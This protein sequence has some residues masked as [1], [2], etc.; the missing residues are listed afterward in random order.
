MRKLGRRQ[1]NLRHCWHSHA[2][3]L[4]CVVIHFLWNSG[5]LDYNLPSADSFLAVAVSDFFCNP[6][7]EIIANSSKKLSIGCEVHFLIENSAICMSLHRANCKQFWEC[8]DALHAKMARSYWYLVPKSRLPISKLMFWQRPF[9]SFDPSDRGKWDIIRIFGSCRKRRFPIIWAELIPLRQL[10]W[11]NPSNQIGGK[12]SKHWKD[13]ERRGM[14]EMKYGRD[15]V[16]IQVLLSYIFWTSVYFFP[17]LWGPLM[18]IACAPQCSFV[19]HGVSFFV[20]L[21]WHWAGVRL[22][23]SHK[24]WINWASSKWAVE[25]ESIPAWLRLAL[26]LGKAWKPIGCLA[27]SS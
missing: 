13:V 4:N 15:S 5:Q 14:I 12:G 24:S 27:S 17:V 20:A 7:L 18:K 6:H 2:I 22:K 25:Q 23:K 11:P 16:R 8:Q 1:Q 19:Y 3:S 10:E 21:T 26:P 9:V